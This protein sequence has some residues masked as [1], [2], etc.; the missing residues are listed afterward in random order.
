[1]FSFFGSVL[2]KIFSYRQHNIDNIEGYNV[3]V[4]GIVPPAY[5]VV[6][7]IM[8][9]LI[10]LVSI[11]SA[12]AVLASVFCCFAGCAEKQTAAVPANDA[13]GG[14]FDTNSVHK[15]EVTLTAEDWADLKANPLAKT[16]YHADVTI[17]G[18]TV[19]DVSFSTKGNTSLANIAAS[20]SDRYSFKINFGK[21]AD[22]QTYFGLNKLDL[23]NIMA[24]STY[25][26]DYISYEIMRR[27]GV[28]APFVSYTELYV[29]GELHGLY[30]AI[31]DESASGKPLLTIILPASSEVMPVP[32]PSTEA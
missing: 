9:H 12:C 25:M 1:M 2:F 8:K 11:L 14:L 20:D 26:K 4:G 22:G 10:K 32:S 29:N 17:D 27:A 7:S 23:N 13:Y 24:D 31:E 16:K 6:R 21:Y 3:H 5:F 19:K 28:P 15:T 30:I 18:N